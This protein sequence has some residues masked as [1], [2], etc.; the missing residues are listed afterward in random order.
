MKQRKVAQLKFRMKRT[1][2][3]SA[4]KQKI[5]SDF[6]R[7][8]PRRI[9]VERYGLKNLSNL[10]RIVKNQKNSQQTG[11]N[12]V[13]L[14]NE[15]N[16]MEIASNFTPSTSVNL[17]FVVLEQLKLRTGLLEKVVSAIEERMT[18]LIAQL[19][20]MFDEIDDREE[21]E[22]EMEEEEEQT[23]NGDV[24]HHCS[25]FQRELFMLNNMQSMFDESLE[26]VNKEFLT[27]MKVFGKYKD[28]EDLNEE[29]ESS[30]SEED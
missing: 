26:A 1:N 2:I 12:T 23:E 22:E 17:M 14:E 29:E 20:A 16:E 11:G 15:D 4:T 3:S 13:Q 24:S 9:I 25:K 18:H 19:K 21:H 28:G 30:S 27:L 6:E 5:I 8:V 7:R 10:Y